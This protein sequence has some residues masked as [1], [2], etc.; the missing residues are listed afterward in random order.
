MWR[1]S[2]VCKPLAPLII[3][4]HTT[5]YPHAT[6]PRVL[7]LV[8]AISKMLESYLYI[9]KPENKILFYFHVKKRECLKSE[10][11]EFFK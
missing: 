5:E 7:R 8:M 3:F 11:D 1:Y 9:K 2:I 6:L 10:K 4:L